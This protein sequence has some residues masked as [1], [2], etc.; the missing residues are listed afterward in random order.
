MTHTNVIRDR[1]QTSKDLMIVGE[2]PKPCLKPWGV[3]KSHTIAWSS[4]GVLSV[5]IDKPKS[6]ID[7][8]IKSN[9]YV[10]TEV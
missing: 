7:V 1:P 6:N 9:I 4:Y 3:D 2:N 10:G 8:G 5:E